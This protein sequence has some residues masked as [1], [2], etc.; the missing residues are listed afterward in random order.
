MVDETEVP[1]SSSSSDPDVVEVKT[2]VLLNSHSE[3][4]RGGHCRLV[5]ADCLP[6]SPQNHD[7]Q[8]LHGKTL[9]C[10]TSL[11]TSRVPGSGRPRVS[12]LRGP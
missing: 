10:L 3:E 6:R 8:G 5:P 2:Y 11:E 7:G 1:L 9:L 12:S 4:T